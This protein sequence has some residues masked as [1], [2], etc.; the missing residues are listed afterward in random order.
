M[1]DKITESALKVISN[2]YQR[3]ITDDTFKG[4]VVSVFETLTK[5]GNTYDP[6]DIIDWLRKNSTLKSEQLS[7][8]ERYAKGVL[9][10][11][12]YRLKMRPYLKVN[13]YTQ[14][15]KELD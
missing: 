4:I 7:E 8:I 9:A 11:T 3:R 2:Q 13:I 10:G 14:W 15:S 6:S 5:N 1:I 12:K